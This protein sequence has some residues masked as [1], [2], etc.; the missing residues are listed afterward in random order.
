M[1]K[2]Q[3]EALD[4]NHEIID[5]PDGTIT[6]IMKGPKDPSYASSPAYTLYPSEVA[7]GDYTVNDGITYTR[8]HSDGWTISGCI[9]EDWFEWVNDFVAT[10][11]DGSFVKGNFEDEIQASS[12]K[13]VRDFLRNHTPSAWD[14][15]DI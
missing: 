7:E 3:I 15:W 5:N 8:T 14:Y 9:T 1:R 6:I 11:K 13:A 10:K 4:W 12:I 2:R